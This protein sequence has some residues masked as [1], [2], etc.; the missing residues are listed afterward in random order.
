MSMAALMGFGGFNT[1]KVR[2]LIF[3]NAVDTDMI[4]F[5]VFFSAP[6][7]FLRVILGQARER[8]C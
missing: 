2:W 4:C 7:I 1:T 8:Q 5:A 6:L 3:V